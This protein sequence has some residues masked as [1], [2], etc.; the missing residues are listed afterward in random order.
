VFGRVVKNFRSPFS[1]G[2]SRVEALA[3]AFLLAV[4]AAAILWFF[5]IFVAAR[6]E[7][8]V[9]S[10][11]R[12]LSL[13]A[14][15]RRGL[16]ERRLQES[17]EELDFVATFPSIRDILVSGRSSKTA[18]AE[19]RLARLLSDFRSINRLRSVSV[20][21]LSGRVLVAVGGP[22]GSGALAL[23]RDVLRDGASRYAVVH[24]PDG[25]TALASAVPVRGASPGN[26]ERPLLGTVLST[27]DA[28]TY[29][30]DLLG[31]PVDA[32][33]SEA[34]LVAADGDDVVFL[35]P[36]LFRPEP[37][38]SFRLPRSAGATAAQA[39]L[40]GQNGFQR[41]TDYR[42]V[43]VFAAVR[44]LSNVPWG[45]VVK[46]DESEALAAFRKDVLQRGLT[47]G[48][49]LLAICA[50][51]VGLWRSLVDANEIRV[52]RSEQGFRNLFEGAADAVFVIGR[53]GR[54]RDANRAAEECYGRS[55]EDLIGLPAADL[56]PPEQRALAREHFREAESGD[57]LVFESEHV[58]ADGSR[59]A[60]EVST[61]LVDLPGDA[62]H[63]AIVRDISARKAAER[64]TQDLN[65]LLRTVA[66]ANE[67]LVRETDESRLFAEICEILVLTGGY[68]LAWIGRAD[69]ETMRVVPLAS[70]G[71]THYLRQVEVRWDDSP[72]GRGPVGTAI[73]EARA[74]IVTDA[75]ADARVGPWR[76]PLLEHGLQSIAAL[77]IRCRKGPA[78]VL[79]VYAPSRAFVDRDEVALLE[80]LAGNLSFALEAMDS[81]DALRRS[82][83]AL[84]NLWRAVEQSPAS[85]VITDLE[86]RIEYVNPQFTR[87]TGY[88]AAEVLGQNPRLLKSGRTSPR[89]YRDLWETITAG[90][91]WQGELC[92]RRKDGTLFWENATISPVRDERGATTSYVAV[93]EDVTARRRAAED[94]AKSEAYFRS[95]IENS[96]DVIAVLDSSGVG[97]YAS[98]SVESTFGFKPEEIVGRSILEFLHPEDQARAAERLQ[99]VVLA[100]GGT[101]NLEVRFRHRDGSWRTISVLGSRL[102][103]EAGVSGVVI[104]AWDITDRL[105]LEA[106]LVQAQKM[107]AV[108]RLAGGVAHD[109]NNLLT[110]I[111]GY[112]ELLQSALVDDA[113]QRESVDEIVRAAERATALTRQ[114]LAFGRKQ[115]LET[116][117]LDVGSVLAETEKLVRRL[118]G[119]DV[120]VH[121][122]RPLTLG[123]VKADP[124]Q[125]EQVVLN[126]VV[127]A[128]DA[129]TGGG[130]LTIALADVDLD[131]PLA[132]AHDRVPPGR[133]VLL[134]I[135]DSGAGIDAETLPHIFEPF[136]TTKEKG[137]GTGLGLATVYG[138]VRQS[139]GFVA[140]ETHPGAGTTFRIYLPRCDERSAPAAHPA[141]PSPRGTETVLL[142]ED[143]PAVRSLAKAILERRGYDVLEA[144]TGAGAL[145]L[146]ARES[147]HI[148]VLLTDLV[149]P[150]MDGRELAARV[151]EL[152]P[153]A[154]VVFMSG[155]PADIA[156]D[157]ASAFIAKPFSESSLAAT[158]RE[159]LD[160]P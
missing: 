80:E 100:S 27:G 136:F 135:A 6:R 148:H 115:V 101:Q 24:E 10:W 112:G 150:G 144:G 77:P 2:R 142:V 41:T 110:V 140:V 73:R 130:R 151:S 121:V 19:A 75:G 8:E 78:R 113:E 40:A 69:R 137:K 103:S 35:S 91:V 56:R 70:A 104:N 60:A 153:S 99:S 22:C 59:F 61:R 92:N 38:L 23:S 124:G 126:L 37:P 156:T 44:R 51:A 154:R 52:A 157:F 139:G 86:G 143:E 119:E 20:V 145:E 18:E 131:A 1:W 33:S 47:W 125:I 160:S 32:P 114:L 9:E 85:V 62:V 149:M 111:H 89:V 95:I 141:S 31:R 58:R 105:Q 128:R 17:G 82:E 28:A 57:R 71:R 134:S 48:A 29:L 65:R 83:A 49:L 94:L 63:I 117:V 152:R 13:R 54:V 127:N 106:Q 66:A 147:R 129:M 96:R 30:F 5:G 53:D 97:R 4:S 109:F 102:P 84:R 120:E 159:V 55:R 116:R 15:L 12:E 68:V 122:S 72:Q 14:D 146:L 67:L 79:C 133:Y 158:I 93:K 21:D 90:G 46:I 16:L 88:T 76:A 34:L 45:L 132:A 98:P 7:A 36:L 74:T 118:I 81:R 64:H 123:R 50:A 3:T 25:A 138:I 87:A 39:A 11:R 107:E 108:G 43:P 155:Y 26:P 42:R